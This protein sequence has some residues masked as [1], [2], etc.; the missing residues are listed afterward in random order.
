MKKSY[1][2]VLLSL[3]ILAAAVIVFFRRTLP[4]ED[5]I[6]AVIGDE[7]VTAAEFQIAWD[8][9]PE[10]KGISP[11]VLLQTLL[12]D[13]ML[14]AMARS[15]GLDR[16]ERFRNRLAEAKNDLLLELFL[17]EEL[18]SIPPPGEE[19]IED[20]WQESAE[21]F[22]V[23]ELIRVSHILVRVRPGEEAESLDTARLL[24]QKVRQGEDFARLALEHSQAESAPRGGDLGFFRPGQLLPE[25]EGVALGMKVGDVAG[26]IRTDYGFHLVKVT[27]RRP[28]R[29]R[30]LIEARDDVVS[31]LLHRHRQEKMIRLQ[32]EAERLYPIWVD[33][34]KFERLKADLEKKR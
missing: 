11:E 13:R 23:P 9:L 33:E 28:A 12:E 29:P 17:E 19:E 24:L 16:S 30:D 27:D 25:L 22:K 15:E 7:M 34:V 21:D 4:G 14:I 8:R 10:P 18:F 5:E 31:A 26:P 32:R 1:L 20:F 6:L 2:L 3:A